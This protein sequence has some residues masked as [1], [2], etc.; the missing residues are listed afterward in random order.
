VCSGLPTAS[1]TAAFSRSDVCH[2]AFAEEGLGGLS[3]AEVAEWL[4]IS[5]P[6]SHRTALIRDDERWVREVMKMSRG[7]PQ[8]I[9]LLI[10]ELNDDRVR[11]GARLPAGLDSYYRS[12]L[13]DH[14]LDDAAG[15][16]PKLVVAT[17]IF[18]EAPSLS[19][20][21]DLLV[22]SGDLVPTAG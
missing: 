5:L 17:A 3:Q 10:E 21:R 6:E 12:L 15:L 19:L 1:L 13:S 11:V 2:H 9:H 14:S 7:L 8:Y 22:V 20:L 16:L 4:R 18:L